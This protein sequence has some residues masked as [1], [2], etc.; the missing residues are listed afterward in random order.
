MRFGK[1]SSAPSSWFETSARRVRS[2]R[3]KTTARGLFGTRS[4]R[5]FRYSPNHLFVAGEMIETSLPFVDH[6]PSVFDHER[7]IRRRRTPHPRGTRGGAQAKD[8]M[9]MGALKSGGAR[10]AIGATAAGVSATE[11]LRPPRLLAGDGPCVLRR[12]SARSASAPRRTTVSSIKLGTFDAR[13]SDCS[14]TNRSTST[15][16]FSNDS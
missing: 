3:W 7:T 13:L 16:T 11:F 6:D 9:S 10:E 14:S 8:A 1:G 12:S 15:G 2:R 4:K 5:V